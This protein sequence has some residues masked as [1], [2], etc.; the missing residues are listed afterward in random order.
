MLSSWV[1]FSEEQLDMK[2]L[3]GGGG[4][5]FQ[6]YTHECVNPSDSTGQ[7]QTEH[8]EVTDYSRSQTT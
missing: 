2:E 5:Y 3:C 7:V 1:P 6:M 8:S 4:D